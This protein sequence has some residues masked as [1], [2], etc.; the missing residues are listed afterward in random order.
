[1]LKI[2]NNLLPFF[3]DSY[4]EIGV[5]EYSRIIKVSPPTASTLL[6]EYE[7]EGILKSKKDRVYLLYRANRES[8]LYV[9]LS[10]LYYK[11]KL[12]KLAEHL[13]EQ[14]NHN[15]IILFGS[16]S[17]GE[18]TG[19]SDIDIYINT[20]YRKIELDDFEKKLNRTIQMHFKPEIKNNEL[21]QNIRQGVVLM[22]T[23]I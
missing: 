4:I 23:M 10:R 12:A 22:G 9:D 13:S 16:L 21:K 19:K 5:R 1:M 6:K 8:S 15:S 2:F 20:E 7:E 18:T 14:S 11:Q 17:K 3:E